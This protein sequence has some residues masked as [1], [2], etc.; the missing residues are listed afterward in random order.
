[1]ITLHLPVVVPGVLLPILTP[2]TFG[3]Y[4]LDSTSLDCLL[5]FLTHRAVL[6]NQ[7]RRVSSWKTDF[8]NPSRR[9][10][11]GRGTIWSS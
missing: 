8:A 10:T 3:S 5:Y 4:S 2:Y 6:P 9:T 11:R 7:V 1:M